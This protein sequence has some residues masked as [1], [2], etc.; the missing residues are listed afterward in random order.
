MSFCLKKLVINEGCRYLKALHADTYEFCDKNFIDNFY[1]NNIKVTAIVG[2]NGCGKSSLLE[3]IFRMMNNL[4]VFIAHGYDVK[5]RVNNVF[6]AGLNSDLYYT[7]NDVNCQLVCRNRSLAFIYGDKK[8]KFGDDNDEFTGYSIGNGMATRDKTA[9]CKNVFFTLAS[10]FSIQAYIDADY[11]DDEIY[12]LNADGT[13]IDASSDEAWIHYV[14]HKNDGYM[15]PININPFRNKGNLDMLKEEKL[16]R[17]RME[18]LLLHYHKEKKAFIRG[19]E[20]SRIEYKF[21]WKKMYYKFTRID[22]KPDSEEAN[23]AEWDGNISTFKNVLNNNQSIAKSILREV[24]VRH[25]NLD[26]IMLVYAYLYIVY[27]VL[28]I[29]CIY[30]SYSQ[31]ASIADVDLAFK[32]GS[33]E[34]RIYAT[35]LAKDIYL[36][37]SHITNKVYQAL[38]FIN[39]IENGFVCNEKNS[40]TWD[41]YNN[42][43]VG[44]I[45]SST[46]IENEIRCLPP[47]FFDFNIY[48]K[49]NGSEDELPI[50]Y[51]S[52]GERQ[53][54]YIL[55]TLIYHILN[56]KSVDIRRIHYR[57]IAIVLDEVE[58]GFHPDYQRKFINF[59]ID[60][61]KRL[62]LNTFVRFHLLIT[63]H[64]PFMLSDILKSNIIYLEKGHKKNKEELMNPFGANINDILAQSFFMKNGF[65][66]SFAQEKINS[67]VDYLKC[68][69]N[70]SS[71]WTDNNIDFLIE[72]VGDPLVSFQLKKL[73]AFKKSRIGDNYR[74]WLENELS[75]LR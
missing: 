17:Q 50:E 58:L 66:G 52:A 13:W 74:E 36:D 2:K 26:N 71:T 20:L 37:H 7:I 73:V 59:M 8:W 60:T 22:V 31:F 25:F 33:E 42:C 45:N 5:H 29:A 41:D 24:G 27:K 39:I 15:A 72:N 16:E 48:L 43:N 46:V 55:S 18:F 1:G 10:N 32:Q 28:N 63:T 49:I 64:S 35:D 34:Q 9:M 47:S 57:D 61:F 70:H 65:V 12:K 38:N 44:A 4:S 14:F 6:V 21:D 54:Y 19:Y 40:F 3:I 69:D 62:H 11:A 67:L 68:D 75:K 23:K 30:P 53:L 51:M 56:I